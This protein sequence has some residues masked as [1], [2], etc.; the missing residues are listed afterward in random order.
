M[1]ETEL[2]LSD[3]GA[4]IMDEGVFIVFQEFDGVVNS[5]VLTAD[6]LRALLAAE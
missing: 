4:T 3:G 2:I 1:P 5:V 6:D